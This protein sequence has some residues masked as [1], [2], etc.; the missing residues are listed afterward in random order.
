MFPWDMPAFMT[1]SDIVLQSRN[2][3]SFS[4]L[5][6]A[7]SI[8]S[9]KDIQAASNSGYAICLTADEF[10]KTFGVSSEE[11]K[12]IFYSPA[13]GRVYY[14]DDMIVFPLMVVGNQFHSPQGMTLSEAIVRCKQGLEQKIRDNKYYFIATALNDRMRMEYLRMLIERKKFPGL[15]K[16]FL[17]IYMFSDY[18]CNAIGMD[19]LRAVMAE[20]PKDA[21]E[22]TRKEIEQ[23]P[24]I[25]TLYRGCGT[26]SAALSETISWTLNP[27]VAVFFAVRLSR[28]GGRIYTAKLKRED[29]CE[30]IGGDEEECFVFPENI[31]DPE[32]IELYGMDW[33]SSQ[34]DELT[35]TYLSYIENADY[36][37]MN[38]ELQSDLHGVTHAHHVLF[39]CLLLA[40]LYN[41]EFEDVDALAQAA[42]Y[43]DTGRISEWEDE[44][45][46][47]YSAKKY[48]R[49]CNNPDPVTLYLMKYHCKPDDVGMRAVHEIPALKS[50]PERAQRLLRIFKDADGLDRIRL[51]KYALDFTQLRTPEAKK[52]LL[53][54]Q[55]AEQLQ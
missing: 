18:G 17:D 26:E 11:L 1:I 35:P 25:V 6:S 8:Q 53:I 7:A 54:A 24:P 51:G 3:E 31:V 27:A 19:S 37:R 48:K 29:I 22:R 34:M 13:F 55:L 16:L 42:L 20:K 33:L 44:K 36:T 47:T 10:Q 50:Q 28:D 49:F 39:F 2:A 52:L 32:C 14:W 4:T 41:L 9:E 5:I 38:F 43:H 12:H 46:G 40:N 15:Y 45:H 30:V 23:L 21:Q